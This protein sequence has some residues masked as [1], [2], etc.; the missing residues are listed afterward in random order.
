ME[1]GHTYCNIETDLALHRD[2]LERYRS[3]GSSHQNV[4]AK[5][6]TN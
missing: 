2:R 1:R 5:P 4:G 3:V 6:S